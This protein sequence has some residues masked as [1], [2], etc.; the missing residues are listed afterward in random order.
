MSDLGF[1][2]APLLLNQ[3]TG[4]GLVAE[5][6]GYHHLTLYLIGVG[7]V[8]AGTLVI[9]EA[10]YNALTPATTGS[11]STWSTIGTLTCA[12]VTGGAQ[13]AFQLPIGAYANVR[14]RFTA[15]VTGGGTISAILVGH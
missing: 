10:W 8:S 12:D 5:C 9:E 11:W 4:I 13:Q 1:L 15:D 3:T 14:A 2:E 6:G 7:T